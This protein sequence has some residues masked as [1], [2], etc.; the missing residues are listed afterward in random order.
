M[1]MTPPR[2][3]ATLAF[4]RTFLLVSL[5]LGILGTAGELI[6]LGHVDSPA[7]WIP[8]VALAAAVPVLLWHAAAP[9]RR[10]VRTVQ[11]LMAAFVLFGIVGVALHYDGN[12]E[13]ESELHPKDAGMTYLR[14]VIAGAT[15]LLAPGSMVLLGL[16]G[17]AHTYRHPST[18]GGAD[19]QE[20]VL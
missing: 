15:P 19:R 8:L 16:L 18:A 12:A 10:T 3:P 4:I 7:Q 1:V 14:H 11:V 5:V 2:E 9:S 20:R 17:I 6:L 13:F